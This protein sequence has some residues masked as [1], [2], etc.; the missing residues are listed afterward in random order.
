MSAEFLPAGAAVNAGA[1]LA[2]VTWIGAALAAAVVPAVL[3]DR[4]LSRRGR[5]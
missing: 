5:G 3:L 1:G 2:S 4:T